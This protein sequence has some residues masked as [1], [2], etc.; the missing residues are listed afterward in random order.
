MSYRSRISG[1]LIDRVDMHVELAPLD[2]EM[3]TQK[4]RGEDSATIRQ[5]VLMARE[6]QRRRYAGTGIRDNASLS[7]KLMDLYCELNTES[8]MALQSLIAELQLSA[9]A[10][11][12]ILRVARTLAD[13]DGMERIELR[14]VHE[15]ANYRILDRQQW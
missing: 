4:R 7:G 5:R 2:S 10:Y 14:H 12:R 15:A 11:D 1:P 9:R 6:I 3:L 13:L 8:A